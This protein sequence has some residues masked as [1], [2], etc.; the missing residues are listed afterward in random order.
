MSLP[1][2]INKAIG[3][4]GMWKAR[5]RSAVD[6][7]KSEFAVETVAKDNQC[8]FGKWLYGSTLTAADKGSPE[9]K[10]VKELHAKFHLSAS[11]VLR[12]ALGGK[13]ADA[14]AQLAPTGEFASISGQLTRA[15][16]A[17]KAKGP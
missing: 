12:D 2:E 5:L 15:M 16:T 7:G 14:E 11:K 17:W 10:A 9:Y 6:T 1:D 13:K 8:D 3:A 4:H